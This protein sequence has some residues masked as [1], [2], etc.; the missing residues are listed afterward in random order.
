[1]NLT[2]PEFNALLHRSIIETYRDYWEQMYSDLT[3]PVTPDE[4]VAVDE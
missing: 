4:E 1:M 3:Y 2:E